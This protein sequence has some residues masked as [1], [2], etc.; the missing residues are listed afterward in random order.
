MTTPTPL[1]AAGFGQSIEELVLERLWERLENVRLSHE[2]PEALEQAAW[3][4]AQVLVYRGDKD[5]RQGHL[6]ILKAAETLNDVERY[7]FNRRKTHVGR[8]IREKLASTCYILRNRLEG[9]DFPVFGE[10]WYAAAYRYA[11]EYYQSRNCQGA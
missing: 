9:T 3:L 7:C 6:A 4:Y 11:E 5:R 2:W 1:S 10:I 8:F